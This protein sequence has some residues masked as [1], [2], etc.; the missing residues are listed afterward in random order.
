[1]IVV[2]ISTYHL[3]TG[4]ERNNGN[5]TGFLKWIYIKCVKIS[6]SVGCVPCLVVII[7]YCWRKNANKMARFPGRWRET[8]FKGVEFGGKTQMQLINSIKLLIHKSSEPT[9]S[10]SS[11]TLL[12]LM[13]ANPPLLSCETPVFIW[14]IAMKR[15]GGVSA[16]VC[17]QDSTEI[18]KYGF[19]L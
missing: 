8:G 3:P 4:S 7:R 19:W 9:H 11:L 10:S 2:A 17:K 6:C 14:F 13:R 1:M 16:E 18:C 15:L 12:N 5:S